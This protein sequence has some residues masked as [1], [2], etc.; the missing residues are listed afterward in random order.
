MHGDSPGYR[1]TGGNRIFGEFITGNRVRGCT[2]GQCIDG[3]SPPWGGADGEGGGGDGSPLSCLDVSLKTSLAGSPPTSRPLPRSPPAPLQ[4][5]RAVH[6]DSPGYRATGSRN[7]VDGR[8]VINS[9]TPYRCRIATHCQHPAARKAGKS[10]GTALAA[11]HKM[12][13]LPGNPG[14]PAGLRDPNPLTF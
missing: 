8:E 10:Y 12:R 11:L 5:G 13:L 4:R 14:G 7:G 1:A 6:G 3:E 9:R 2:P